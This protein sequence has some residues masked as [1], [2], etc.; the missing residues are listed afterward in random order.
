MNF[1]FCLLELARAACQPIMYTILL[2]LCMHN[3]IRVKHSSFFYY[4]L[5]QEREILLSVTQ[6]QQ[7]LWELFFDCVTAVLYVSSHQLSLWSGFI[8]SF[9]SVTTA[10]PLNSNLGHKG[11]SFPEGR[12]NLASITYQSPTCLQKT[13]SCDELCII[14][15]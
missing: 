14:L 11:P 6:Q 4:I 7:F 5:W 9:L 13:V 2:V 1:L 12:G 15:M 8:A 3:S 10:P